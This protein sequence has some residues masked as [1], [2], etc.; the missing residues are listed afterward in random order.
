MRIKKS[1]IV[2]M[3]ALTFVCLGASPLLASES[4]ESKFRW[5]II[6]AAVSGSPPNLVV[7]VLPGGLSTSVAALIPAQGTGDDSTITLTGEG[8]FELGEL[9]EVTGGGTWATATKDGSPIASGTYRVTELV[10]FKIAPSDFAATGLVDGFGNAADVR[11][12]LAVLKVHYSDGENGVVVVVCNLGPPAPMTV[13][14]GT[15]ATKGFV[16]YSN[17]ISPDGTTGNTLF[18]VIHNDD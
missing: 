10:F 4:H 8:T 15:T 14:E 16:D 17:P 5:D 9:H 11:A 6:Q 18:H 7:T 3:I 2:S 1:T 13:I 12:G